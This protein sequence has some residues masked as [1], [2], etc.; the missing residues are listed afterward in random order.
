MVE[1]IFPR[2]LLTHKKSLCTDCWEDESQSNSLLSA[3]NTSNSP[4]LLNSPASTRS[5]PTLAQGTRDATQTHLSQAR[6]SQTSISPGDAGA[7]F[8][9]SGDVDTGFLQVYGPEDQLHAEQIELEARLGGESSFSD[10]RQR[11]LLQSFAETYW[12]YCYPFCPVLDRATLDAELERS[13]L[14]TNALA[15]AASHIQPPLVPHDGPAN[16]YN[17]AKAIFY[18]EGEADSMTALKAL[19][20]FYW[21][22]PRAPSTAHRTSSWWWTSVIIRI[23]QQMNIHREVP[24]AHPARNVLD[25]SLRRR[26][27]WTVFVGVHLVM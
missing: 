6:L 1:A 20:L 24:Q 19:T 27:W 7:G 26:L 11:E 23:A 14:L 4:V 25:L 2:P 15:L 16:Y 13:T 5:H 9:H 21:W 10:P 12:E 18:N 17:K 3:P 8:S 22:A